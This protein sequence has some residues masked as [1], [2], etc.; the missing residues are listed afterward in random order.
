MAFIHA[1][2]PLNISTYQQHIS[3][4][5]STLQKLTETPSNPQQPLTKAIKEMACFADKRLN[6]LATKI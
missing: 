4:L 5:H 2:I 3:L 1:A 6:K